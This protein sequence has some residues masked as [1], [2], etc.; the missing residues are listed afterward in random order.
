[1]EHPVP[2]SPMPGGTPAPDLHFPFDDAEIPAESRFLQWLTRL[3]LSAD[4]PA[5]ARVA[6]RALD[7]VKDPSAETSRF[8]AFLAQATI[9]LSPLPRRRGRLRH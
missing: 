4:V 1:M 8:R 3:P 7:H 2:T 9:P 6:L 5:A